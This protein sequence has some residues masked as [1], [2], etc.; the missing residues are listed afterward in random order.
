ML[1]ASAS[2]KRSKQFVLINRKKPIAELDKEFG[3]F[4]E[5]CYCGGDWMNEE[6]VLCY[7]EKVVGNFSFGKEG[8]WVSPWAIF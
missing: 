2:G 8:A 6:T 5:L 1:T 7:L 4:L 3:Q